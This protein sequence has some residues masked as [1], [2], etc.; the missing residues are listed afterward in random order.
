MYKKRITDEMLV[1]VAS[2]ISRVSQD[3]LIIDLGLNYLT[4]GCISTLKTLFG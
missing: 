4:D 1:D 2:V 3:N